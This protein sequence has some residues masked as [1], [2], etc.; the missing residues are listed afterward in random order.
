[1]DKTNNRPTWDEYFKKIC[2]VTKD[3]S[4]CDR[5][6]V[7]CL[8][9]LDNRIVSQG[10]N[11]FPRGIHDNIGLLEDKKSKYDRIVHAE[12]NVIYN[13]CY[14]GVS[15]DG[16]SLYIYGLPL[17]SKCCLGVIQVGIKRVIMKAPKLPKRWNDSWKLSEKL[18][19]EANIN[20]Y[21]HE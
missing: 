16:A 20:F 13:A 9:V 19:S 18:L 1:M 3:R 8:L 14:N 4:S 12:M 2:S 10:Y 21:L 11:G 6:K 15:L 17:C 5:L 7:G